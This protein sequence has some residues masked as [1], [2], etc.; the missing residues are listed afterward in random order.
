MTLASILS[1]LDAAVPV[2]RDSPWFPKD[3]DAWSVR[4]VFL[5]VI[6]ELAR[7]AGHADIIRES[8]D[9]AKSMG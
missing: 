8:L 1:L 7:H 6:S 4:W 2:P 9:G 5:H 3:V